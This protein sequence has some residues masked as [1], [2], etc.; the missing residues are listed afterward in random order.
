MIN[1][2]ADYSAEERNFVKAHTQVT[3]YCDNICGRFFGIHTIKKNSIF[4]AENL[5]TKKPKPLHR[6]RRISAMKKGLTCAIRQASERGTAATSKGAHMRRRAQSNDHGKRSA[7]QQ[8]QGDS[9]CTRE[10]HNARDSHQ[11]TG[12]VFCSLL[13]MTSSCH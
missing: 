2:D 8:P 1:Q 10:S 3:C 4:L 13:I 12:Q 5:L 7:W 9:K 6:A 11:Q